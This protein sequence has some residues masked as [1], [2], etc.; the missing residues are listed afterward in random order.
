MEHNGTNAEFME[1][2]IAA[3]ATVSPVKTRERFNIY[4]E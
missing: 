3:P 1:Q 4:I 2:I